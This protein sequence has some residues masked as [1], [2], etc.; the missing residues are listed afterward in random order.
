MAKKFFV[1]RARIVKGERWYIDYTRLDPE[2]QKET[3][4]RQDFDLNEIADVHIREAVAE[5]LVKHLQ[6]FMKYDLRPAPL[7]AQDM[8]G[9]TMAQAVKHVLKI[10]TAAPRPNTHKNYVTIAGKLLK[11]LDTRSY[12]AMP[13]GEFS[14]R[15]ARAFFDWYMA[16]K[17][18]R[19]VTI[20]NRI[21]HLRSMWSELVDR[22]IVPD[23]PWKAIK[24][25]QEEEK[26]RRIFEPEERRIIAR[27]IERTDYWLFRGLL[28]Q[29]FC[30]IRP[31]ELHRL[32]FKDFDFSTGTVCVEVW[33]GKR[34]RRR[35]ATIPKSVRHYFLDGRFEKYP[36][37][38][39]VF[40]LTGDGAYQET[41][42]SPKASHP[43][44]MYKRHRR[45]LERLRAA[46][47]LKHIEN[48][49]WYGWKDTGIS[50]HAHRTTPLAT[51]DQAGHTDFDVTLIY[52]HAD[53][54]N[55]E[56]AALPNDLF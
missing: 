32:R 37:N 16:Q 39:F 27:E 38:Y 36:G 7:A 25:V 12:A 1:S 28:L 54:V 3:R 19:G 34:P 4:H 20:N 24:P 23:N 9:M 56:Y 15:H 30:Y 49:T 6:V 40:G 13:A 26:L 5:R 11:W 35:W 8:P 47:H 44:R 52:Y 29:F 18:Y 48:L 31:V 53:Q 21:V 50:L 55:A 10:K 17:K 43:N 45:V 41:G 22:E 33:K 2:T 46:G 51:K 14:K 42:A